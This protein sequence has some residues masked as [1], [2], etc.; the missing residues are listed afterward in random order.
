MNKKLFALLLSACLLLGLL[1]G[2]GDMTISSSHDAPDSANAKSISFGE[3]KVKTKGGGM[4]VSGSVVTISAAGDYAISGSAD[5]AQIIV[6]TGD[7]AG[8]VRLILNNANLTN[9]ADAVISVQQA[10]DLRLYIEKDS[11]NRLVS[12]FEGMEIPAGTDSS[13]AVIFSEDDIDIE[14]E[15]SLQIFG[16]INNGITGKDDVDINSGTIEI[17]AANNGIKGSE[18]VDIKGGSLTV[19]SGNDGIKSSSAAKAGKGYVNVSGGSVSV[20][21]GGDGIA[22]ETELNISGGSIS[23][24][25]EGDENLASCKGLKGKTALTVSGGSISVQSSDHGIHSGA[26]LVISGGEINVVSLRSKGIASHGD[27]DITGGNVVIEVGD[28]GI[29]TEG[30]FCLAGGNV[31]IV[32]GSDGIKFGTTGTGFETEKAELTL[33][34]GKLLINANSDAID[35]R[36]QVC[37]SGGELLALG[38][39]KTAGAFEHDSSQAVLCFSIKGLSGT[40]VSIGDFAKITARWDYNTLL[41]SNSG[42]SHGTEYTATNGSTAAKAVAN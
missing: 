37:I 34:G 20:H 16:Y 31:D 15:G 29:E 28:D 10:K 5:D 8:R 42:L 21:S 23:V 4:S 24:V 17:F 35:A 13:G 36:G 7:D 2:C 30:S 18:S 33:S 14:G 3:G 41:C 25:T 6:N 22:A 27:I 40:E 9:P 32:S 39:G 38:N 12:G 1:S 19:T 11:S 26:A